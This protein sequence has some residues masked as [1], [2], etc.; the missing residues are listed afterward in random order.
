NL[1][2]D[3]PN[4][5]NRRPRGS[6]SEATVGLGPRP[7]PRLVHVFRTKA[8]VFV[9]SCS[10]RGAVFRVDVSIGVRTSL[11]LQGKPCRQFPQPKR[12]Q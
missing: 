10:L 7:S 11:G 1:C 5:T 9:G 3:W 6:Q 2:S 8:A 12:A 4:G